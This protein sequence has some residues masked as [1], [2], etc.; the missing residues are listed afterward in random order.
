MVVRLV[1]DAG[2]R[3]HSHEE[4]VDLIDVGQELLA[5]CGVAD[6]DRAAEGVGCHG[7]LQGILSRG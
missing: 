2:E 3:D 5:N 1:D 4:V 7:F 6:S